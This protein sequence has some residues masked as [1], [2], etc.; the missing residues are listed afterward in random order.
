MTGIFR[1]L[2]YLITILLLLLS[3]CGNSDYYVT[4][5]WSVPTT[6]TDGSQMTDLAGYE[7]YMGKSSG[8]YTR[9]TRIPVGDSM[10][11]CRDAE[12]DK[13]PKTAKCSYTVTGLPQGDYYFVVSAYNT[14][15]NKS[16][17][18]N[19]VKKTALRFVVN[20]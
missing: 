8:N 3:G 6:N 1:S 4:L 2:L 13:F 15:G 16:S 12:A 18:S 7:L 17:H 5:T 11:L 14:F 20:K 19:E 9:I 10:L